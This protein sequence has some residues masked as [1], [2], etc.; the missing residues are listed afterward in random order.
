[1]GGASTKAPSE[2]SSP[3]AAKK[4]H[5]SPYPSAW[6]RGWVAFLYKGV[7]YRILHDKYDGHYK[8]LG[9]AVVNEIS[10]NKDSI[11]HLWRTL[12]DCGQVQFDIDSACL[13]PP[14]EGDEAETEWTRALSQ[15]PV[16]RVSSWFRGRHRSLFSHSQFFLIRRSNSAHYYVIDLD[17]GRFLF[18][19]AKDCT[20]LVFGH[21][22]GEIPPDWIDRLENYH[23][24]YDVQVDCAFPL[25]GCIC[26]PIVQDAETQGYAIIK[27]VSTYFTHAIF[28]GQRMD[29]GKLVDFKVY[30]VDQMI[31]PFPKREAKVAAFLEQYPHENLL[32]CLDQREFHNYPVFVF[33]CL[34]HNLWSLFRIKTPQS[35][36]AVVCA[37]GQVARAVIHLLRHG[38]VH[39]DVAPHNI[40]IRWDETSSEPVHAFL[41]GFQCASVPL[42]DPTDARWQHLDWGPYK[43]SSTN[44]I[45]TTHVISDKAISDQPNSKDDVS[46]SETENETT[47]GKEAEYTT[48]HEGE[49]E[50]RRKRPREGDNEEEKDDAE[51]EALKWQA[52]W[53]PLVRTVLPLADREAMSPWAFDCNSLMRILDF[54][55][56]DGSI[57]SVATEMGIDGVTEAKNLLQGVDTY[58]SALATLHKVAD[59]LDPLSMD[60]EIED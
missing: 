9:T 16:G 56:G 30:F 32:G 21:P 41:W 53:E 45:D 22:L 17:S 47:K 19:D 36:Q 11:L 37:V 33:E 15:L 4:A 46:V 24:G 23:V 43:S 29:D 58:E 7:Y 20:C 2:K 10:K 35:L 14:P 8:G 50:D 18:S 34:Q 13:Q 60:T 51:A 55:A 59:I 38:V 42:I 28:H 52:G 40:L 44:E 5:V 57:E 31:P 25:P 3:P 6:Q 48:K 1:M 39:F 27:T 26:K 12:F 49:Q 54:D